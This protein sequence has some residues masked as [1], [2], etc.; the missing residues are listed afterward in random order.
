[1]I[2][3]LSGHKETGY[4]FQSN[5]YNKLEDLFQQRKISRY[6]SMSYRLK[7]FYLSFQSLVYLNI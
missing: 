1:M 4:L 5:Y 3:M 7:Y 2:G 6:A